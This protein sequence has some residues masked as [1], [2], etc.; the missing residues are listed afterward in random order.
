MKIHA[1][2]W[3]NRSVL[4]TGHTGF[5]GG[6]LT[7]WL[8]HLGANIHGYSLEPPTQLNLFDVAKIAKLLT[9]E[10]R[11]D[12]ADLEQL[13]STIQQ[14]RPEIIFHLAAQPLVRES[15]RNPLGT[16][17]SN[18]LGTAH[19][20]E[21]ARTSDSIRAIII[22]TTDKVYQNREHYHAYRE[23]DALGGHDPYSASKAAAE[24][25]TASYRESFFNEESDHPIRVATV[26]AGNV[27]GGGDWAVDRL[28][29]DCLRAFKAKKP[30][31]LR[32]PHAIRPWQHVLEPLAG[33]LQLAE[34]LLSA[35]GNQFARAWNFGPDAKGDATVSQVAEM[36]AQRWG[37]N[38]HIELEAIHT[39]LHETHLLKL[40]S[41]LAY[42]DLGW[43][44]RWSL[45]K[46]LEQVVIWHKAWH[47]DA[48]MARITLSQISAYQE[49]S[50][51]LT[52]A[53][54]P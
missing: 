46:A 24:L 32:F 23:T 17:T 2:V 29:P 22:V 25:V 10:T 45:E 4:I 40:D 31:R 42:T 14:S 33:Y 50:L 41:T 36:L 48:D 1:N 20:L 13:K 37:D 5:K 28:V 30:V 8:H 26:R 16:L 27:I 3:K 51:S 52:P 47:Q 34:H 39:P 18:I 12:L 38:A 53:A 7:S 35:T 43:K 54:Q 15:Y 6:W 21:A 11:A 49:A 44:P 9:S 19:V